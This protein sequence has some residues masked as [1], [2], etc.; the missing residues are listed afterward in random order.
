MWV[1]EGRVGGTAVQAEKQK[2]IPPNNKPEELLLPRPRSSIRVNGHKTARKKKNNN[3]DDTAML[4]T[5]RLAIQ[6]LA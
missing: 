4:F 6:E 2:T 3:N 5:A 1:R